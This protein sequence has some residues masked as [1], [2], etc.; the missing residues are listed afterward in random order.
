[1][2]SFGPQNSAMLNYNLV[3]I[4]HPNFIDISSITK[5]SLQLSHIL[6]QTAY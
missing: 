3:I 5:T 6:R 1:M 4:S 2:V